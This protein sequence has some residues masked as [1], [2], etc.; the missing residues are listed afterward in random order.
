VFAPAVALDIL[1]C[2]H[3]LLWF[4]KGS[5]CA[6]LLQ[7]GHG[8]TGAATWAHW[9]TSWVESYSTPYR[10]LDS[11][12]AVQQLNGLFP[13][14]L[15]LWQ[16]PRYN[17]ALRV[18]LR[19]YLDANAASPIESGIALAQ[20]ALESLAYAHLVSAAR[21]PAA[22]GRNVRANVTLRRL[23]SLLHVPTA[24]PRQVATL[25]DAQPG[26][27]TRDPWDGASAV[28]WLRN[29]AMHGERH[30]PGPTW[31]TWLHGWLLSCWYVE[32]TVLALC[33]YRGVYRSRIHS[34]TWTGSVRKVPWARAA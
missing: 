32:M 15:T 18:A 13:L 31:R 29:Y 25:R 34:D 2:L 7:V 9:T 14:F 12:H 4:S 26:S 22:F 3:Y 11:L 30:T 23:L 5:S 16:D 8:R 17:A 20:L 33:G 21:D 27:W 24:I 28:T 10:W 6:P 19:N 1:E